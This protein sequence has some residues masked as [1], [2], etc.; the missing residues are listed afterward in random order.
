MLLEMQRPEGESEL[1]EDSEATVGEDAHAPFMQLHHRNTKLHHDEHDIEYR[2]VPLD[3]T[4]PLLRVSTRSY[5]GA[6]GNAETN[7][8]GDDSK[9]N[10]VTSALAASSRPTSSVRPAAGPAS[11]LH[12]PN[13]RGR[14]DAPPRTRREKIAKYREVLWNAR[15]QCDTRDAALSAQINDDDLSLLLYTRDKAY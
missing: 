12:A 3:F 6:G 11:T 9:N 13:F 4:L 8:E 14:D 10:T 7:D 2:G 5:T 1:L 15:H